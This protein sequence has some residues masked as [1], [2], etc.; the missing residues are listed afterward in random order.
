MILGTSE[1]AKIAKHHEA[2]TWLETSKYVNRK[3][4]DFWIKRFL[5]DPEKFDFIEKHFNKKIVGL[6]TFLVYDLL[7]YGG[8]Y[9]LKKLLLRGRNKRI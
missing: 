6:Y 4:K 1:Y 2:G 8:I 5:R 3:Y 9:Y 7:E